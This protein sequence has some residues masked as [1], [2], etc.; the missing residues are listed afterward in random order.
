MKKI[1]LVLFSFL[2][3]FSAQAQEFVEE[4]FFPENRV[5]DV[6]ECGVYEHDSSSFINCINVTVTCNH[7]ILIK[8]IGESFGLRMDYPVLNEKTG[9]YEWSVRIIKSAID[10]IAARN[11]CIAIGVDVKSPRTLQ[12]DIDGG[13]EIM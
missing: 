6:R 5:V 2:A 3:C 8:P 12:D 1:L 7:K 9:E 11:W 13:S 10:D 4:G